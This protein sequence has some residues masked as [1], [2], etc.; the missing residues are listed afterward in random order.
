LSRSIAISKL[1]PIAIVVIVVTVSLI[2]LVYLASVRSSPISGSSGVTCNSEVDS[3][4]V[5]IL[6]PSGASNPSNAPGYSPDAVTL[7]IGTNNT[8]TWTNNDAVHHTVTSSSAPSGASFNSGD[9][10]FDATYTC[11]FTTP[12]TYK[13]YCVYHS[14]MTGTI[15]VEAAS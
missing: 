10:G 7:V 6:I 4:A 2:G 9:M 5:Q 11:T 8:V 13:Y 3:S 1:V 14:W 15:M 12:G